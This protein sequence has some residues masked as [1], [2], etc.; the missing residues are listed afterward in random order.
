M[1]SNF[2]FNVRLKWHEGKNA[3]TE[4][5]STSYISVPNKVQH[6]STDTPIA[7]DQTLKGPQKLPSQQWYAVGVHLK[8][9]GGSGRVSHDC[10]LHGL[11]FP[12][13]GV[14]VFV[15]SLFSCC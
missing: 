7:T 5:S 13:E 12:F 10:F 2:T 14:D 11:Q 15:S 1:P 9:A 8:A 4:A 6:I 3:A